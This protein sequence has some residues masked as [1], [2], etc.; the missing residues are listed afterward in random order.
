MTELGAQ[1]ILARVG[2]EARTFARN[3]VFSTPVLDRVARGIAGALA[4]E[5]YT[6]LEQPGPDTNVVL[7]TMESAAPR[8]YRR[9]AAPTFV[10]ALAELAGAPGVARGAPARPATRSWCAASRICA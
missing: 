9:K 4:G 5:G 6:E 2:R 8:P 10:I 3:E 1:A 7:H